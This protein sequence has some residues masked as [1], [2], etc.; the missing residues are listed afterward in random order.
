[1]ACGA[2]AVPHLV[3]VATDPKADEE[4]RMVALFCLGRIGGDEALATAVKLRTDPAWRMRNRAV[5][6]LYDM[7]KADEIVA[8]LT[9]EHWNVRALAIRALGGLG[10]KDAV[11]EFL[12]NDTKLVN[13]AGPNYIKYDFDTVVRWIAAHEL[14]NRLFAVEEIIAAFNEATGAEKARLANVLGA[15]W[16]YRATETLRA[17]LNDADETVRLACV[18]NLYKQGRYNE[19]ISL[20]RNENADVRAEAGRLVALSR[21]PL[22]IEQL[23]A[24]LDDTNSET[25]GQAALAMLLLR[26]PELAGRLAPADPQGEKAWWGANKE[27]FAGKDLSE[28]RLIEKPDLPDIDLR[29]IGRTPRYDFDAEK[30]NPAP[31]DKVTGRV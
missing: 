21:D 4:L 19:L 13:D 22:L 16:D 17:A 2:K 25:V 20:L 7:G 9:D 1:L 8:S 3:E 29:Y 28:I 26:K 27:K 23:A 11:I 14:Q 30:N 5:L 6:A 15:L 18:D 24:L 10:R 31:G 12:K